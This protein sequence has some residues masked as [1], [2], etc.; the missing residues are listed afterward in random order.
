VENNV[1]ASLDTTN[2]TFGKNRFFG[3]APAALGA[4]PLAPVG[5]PFNG[6]R[7]TSQ[8][9]QNLIGK[10]LDVNGDGRIDIP[11]MASMRL[12]TGPDGGS[13]TLNLN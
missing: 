11:D 6:V 9:A 1:A 12:R 5:P 10:G 8:D 2:A 4:A 3:L 13:R 7:L